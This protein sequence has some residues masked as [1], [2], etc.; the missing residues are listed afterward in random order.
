MAHDNGGV[1]SLGQRWKL[2]EDEGGGRLKVLWD[3]RV[4]LER[5][6]KRKRK[7]NRPISGD[8]G[9]NRV[10]LPEKWKKVFEFGSRSLATDLN[11]NEMDFEITFEIKEF[12][13]SNQN[14]N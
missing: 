6:G 9:R 11:L 7:G 13:N 4:L 10:G 3:E 14:L 8:L 12:W 2:E 5:H 1:A